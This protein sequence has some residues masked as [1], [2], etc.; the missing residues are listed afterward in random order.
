MRKIFFVDSAGCRNKSETFHI[1]R[2]QAVNTSAVYIDQEA[3]IGW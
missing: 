3:N 1:D 2:K